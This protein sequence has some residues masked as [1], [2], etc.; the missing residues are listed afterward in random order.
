MY[1]HYFCYYLH[2]EKDISFTCQ[3]WLKLALWFW[4]ISNGTQSHI[5]HNHSMQL[6]FILFSIFLTK[7]IDVRIIFFFEFSLNM[8]YICLLS[9]AC[10]HFYLKGMNDRTTGNT[11]YSIVNQDTL[12]TNQ[13]DLNIKLYDLFISTHITTMT[14]ITS[15]A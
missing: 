1:F 5:K 2:L 4:R 8:H 9:N 13:S 11:S 15:I 3:V 12:I 7:S 6:I 10:I 14:R